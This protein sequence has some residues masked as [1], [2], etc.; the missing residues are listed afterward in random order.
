MN[1]ALA[2]EYIDMPLFEGPIMPSMLEVMPQMNTCRIYDMP[3]ERAYEWVDDR[4]VEASKADRLR[5][6]LARKKI[7][8]TMANRMPRARI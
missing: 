2:V 6:Q 5:E 7:A 8:F 4:W 1:P 3:E